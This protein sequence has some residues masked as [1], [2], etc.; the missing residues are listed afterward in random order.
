MQ[1]LVRTIPL[2]CQEKV[3]ELTDEEKGIKIRFY[4]SLPYN[5]VF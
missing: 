5:A 4:I 3:L 2:A 1:D